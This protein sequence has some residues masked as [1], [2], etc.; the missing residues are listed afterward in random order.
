LLGGKWI[1]GRYIQH[2]I[3]SLVAEKGK[4]S[5]AAWWT[6]AAALF[7][8]VEDVFGSL[9]PVH[10]LG[11]LRAGYCLAVL[12]AFALPGPQAS[13]TDAPVYGSGRHR[14]EPPR[15]SVNRLNP[16]ELTTLFGD[17][18]T[19]EPGRVPVGRRRPEP[20]DR[21]PNPRNVTAWDA[22]SHKP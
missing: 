8:T 21:L 4:L 13:V 18:D 22:V 17:L 19:V 7:Y 9:I 10:L 11:V 20:A 3:A 16:A 15:R 2:Q 6:S 14:R 1:R 5:A 12:A